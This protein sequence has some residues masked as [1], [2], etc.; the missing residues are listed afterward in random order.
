MACYRRVSYSAVLAC[1]ILVF[2][3]SDEAEVLA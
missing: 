1:L 2:D 3:D